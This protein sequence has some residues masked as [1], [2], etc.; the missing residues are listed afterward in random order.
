[1][2]D[3][4]LSLKF[5]VVLM[6]L[7]RQ[8]DA[9]INGLPAQLLCSANMNLQQLYVPR[10]Y[11]G[12]MHGTRCCTVRVMRHSRDCVEIFPATCLPFVSFVVF[13]KRRGEGVTLVP[14]STQ[15]CAGSSEG[16]TGA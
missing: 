2:K 6:T 16:S 7:P 8:A 5:R 13:S 14:R 10:N 3:V 1:M 4:F 11:H 9:L 12:N 15:G